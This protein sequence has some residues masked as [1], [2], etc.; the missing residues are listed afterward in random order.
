[1]GGD[2]Y[3]IVTGTDYLGVRRRSTTDDIGKANDLL[4]YDSKGTVWLARRSSTR[5]RIL[6]KKGY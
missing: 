5:R 2:L 4:D 6:K 1:M 3:Y